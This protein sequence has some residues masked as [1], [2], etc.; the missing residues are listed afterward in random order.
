MPIQPTFC[1]FW[2]MRASLYSLHHMRDRASGAIEHAARRA[3]TKGAEYTLCAGAR[4]VGM[5]GRNASSSCSLL[6]A[7]FHPMSCPRLAQT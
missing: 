7:A 6:F 3:S 5:M 4:C 1:V 2:A